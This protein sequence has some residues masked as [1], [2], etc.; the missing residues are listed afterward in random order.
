[1][2]I[3]FK[4]FEFLYTSLKHN[5]KLNK[6]GSERNILK[7]LKTEKKEQMQKY[8][9]NDD[10]NE[11]LIELEKYI[12]KTSDK[13]AQLFNKDKRRCQVNNLDL[14]K[15]I[16][17]LN[18]V[19]QSTY[20]ASIKTN[21]TKKTKATHYFIEHKYYKNLFYKKSDNANVDKSRRIDL[22]LPGSE[23]FSLNKY[24]SINA[25]SKDEIQEMADVTSD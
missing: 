20:G 23:R 25:F 19:L 8:K 22:Y 18:P 1:M 4:S 3:D 9:I 15:M 24:R 13:I 7:Y 5:I 2:D 21:A 14:T 12:N 16:K 10:F 11:M 6:K 17:W